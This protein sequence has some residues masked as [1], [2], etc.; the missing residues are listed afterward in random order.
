[1]RQ[2]LQLLGGRIDRLA[3]RNH[4]RG[5]FRRLLGWGAPLMALLVTEVDGGRLAGCSLGPLTDYVTLRRDQP[6]CLAHEIGHACN[7][8]HDRSPLNLMNPTCGGIHLRTWQVL[9]L[10]LSRHVTFL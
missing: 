6:L 3:V 10:R 1:M 4:W 9:L 2:D 5:G 7:L 8:L